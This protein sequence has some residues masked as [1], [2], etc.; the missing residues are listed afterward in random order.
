MEAFRKLKEQVLLQE[1]I[2]ESNGADFR[3]LVV[4][5]EI[6]ASMRRQAKEGEFRS[7]LHRGASSNFVHLEEEEKV[8]VKKVVKVLGLDVA[9]VDLLRSNRGPLIME[10]NA[11]PGLE[12]IEN[13]TG[14]DVA[15]KIIDF[16]ENRIK[17]T[18]NS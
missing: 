15:G 12:G 6:V 18:H 10:V 13:T 16:I 1:Y 5:G 8:I 7:N 4:G 9:G 14:I 2:S 17:E 11:S 3:A